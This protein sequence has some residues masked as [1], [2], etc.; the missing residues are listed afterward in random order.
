MNT[1]HNTQSN[2]QNKDINKSGQA[3]KQQIDT[4]VRATEQGGRPEFEKNKFAGDAMW[5]GK[6]D[7][8]QTGSRVDRKESLDRQYDYK[9]QPPEGQVQRSSSGKLKS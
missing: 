3:G 8:V 7:D 4:D 5:S 6:S 9:A 2:Q 1:T